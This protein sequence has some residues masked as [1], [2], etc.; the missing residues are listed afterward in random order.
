VQAESPAKPASYEGSNNSHDDVHDDAKA[1]AVDDTT[2]Q[3]ASDAANNQPEN[4]S[5]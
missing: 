1:T 3:S 4:D 2:G 5:M